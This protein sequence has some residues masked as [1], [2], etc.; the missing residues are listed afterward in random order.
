MKILFYKFFRDKFFLS[1]LFI[2][3]LETFFY[4]YFSKNILAL[5]VYP[6]IG[7][8]IGYVTN[9]IAV[10][11]IFNPKKPLFGHDSLQGLIPKSRKRIAERISSVV[12]KELI[13]P[14]SIKDYLKNNSNIIQK[15]LEKEIKSLISQRDLTFKNILGEKFL[16]YIK[17]G[18][19]MLYQKH[20]NSLA[21][22]AYKILIYQLEKVLK[23][24]FSSTEVNSSLNIKLKEFMIEKLEKFM[25]KILDDFKE[26]TL[27]DFINE[28][29][30]EE[31][32]KK[33]LQKSN[34]EISRKLYATLATKS[35][36]DIYP[37]VD[38]IYDWIMNFLS[39]KLKEEN[40]KKNLARIIASALNRSLTVNR[41]NPGWRKNQIP[42]FSRVSEGTRTSIH[43]NT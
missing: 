17:F 6:T 32:I 30:L 35:L 36:Y 1:L 13:N 26:R 40:F 42:L 8:I 16:R 43:K 28:K 5:F 2:L 33:L 20:T 14:Q 31:E 19:I 12:E 7:A 34:E 9:V 38:K 27:K 11:M 39:E 29:R 41:Q 4:F 10:W 21:K 23:D 24:S 22:F 15:K 25:S 37:R 3:T 18:I